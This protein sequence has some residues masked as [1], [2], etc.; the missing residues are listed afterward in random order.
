MVPWESLESTEHLAH[1]QALTDPSTLK[2]G[3]FC[4]TPCYDKSLGL[5][6]MLITW[7][8]QKKISALTTQMQWPVTSHV[9]GEQTKLCCM[10]SRVCMV[11][12]YL[13][14]I[15]RWKAGILVNEMTT[16]QENCG[17]KNRQFKSTATRVRELLLHVSDCSVEYISE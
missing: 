1:R 13:L 17:L 10:F 6:K 3:E 15:Q 4:N 12:L 8:Y 7:K 14:S 5:H 16:V 11:L 2:R 9:T